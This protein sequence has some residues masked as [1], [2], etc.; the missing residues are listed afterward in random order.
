[1]N[2]KT[3]T[4]SAVS[5]YLPGAVGYRVDEPEGCL[6]FVRGIPHGGRPPRALVLVVSDRITV[7]FISVRRI[8]AVL[9]LERRIVLHPKEAA[10]VASVRRLE[11]AR[12][13]A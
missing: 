2:P 8:A 12:K 11:P 7:R 9:P 10:A 1:V 4:A 13:A 6:G 5:E 3:S